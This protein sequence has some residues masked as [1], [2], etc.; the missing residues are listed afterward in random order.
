MALNEK[1]REDLVAYLDGELPEE[2]AR[3]L[4]AKLSLDPQARA[5]A[6]LLRH[7]WDLLDFLPRLEPSARFT[8]QTLERLAP[9]STSG[10]RGPAPGRARR[11]LL[12]LGWAAAL[13]L[14]ALAGHAGFHLL[15]P[16]GPTEEDLV[17]DLRLIEDKPLYE[18]VGDVQFL[19]DLDNPALFREEDPGS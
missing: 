15:A 11:W 16:D 5:E 12:G 18:L 8:H 7:T 19:K 17:Y 4:E 3:A 10:M 1:E 2:D 14:A 9:V 13:V 6:N